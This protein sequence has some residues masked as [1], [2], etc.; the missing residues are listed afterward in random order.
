M[1]SLQWAPS[2]FRRN[3][4]LL[5]HAI[6]TLPIRAR[7]QFFI[8]VHM[9]TNPHPS[10]FLRALCG[11]V[12]LSGSALT[13]NSAE[14]QA[15]A[16]ARPVMSPAE[17]KAAREAYMA[18]IREQEANTKVVLRAVG[19]PG[20]EPVAM[21]D[22]NDEPKLVM[23]NSELVGQVAEIDVA[24][25][26]VTIRTRDGS[27]RVFTLTDPRPVK[28][29]EFSPQQV[30]MMISEMNRGRPRNEGAPIELMRTWSELSREAKEDILLSYLR[31]GVVIDISS[32]SSAS[33]A[34]LFERQMVQR[35][36]E[37]MDAFL[38]S[39]TPEQRELF[40][41]SSKGL[42]RIGTPPMDKEALAAKNNRASS[43]LEQLLAS[44]TADQRKLY[45]AMRPGQ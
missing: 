13:S 12:L 26:Q 38:A 30:E 20:G 34:R 28:F 32:R 43:S 3:R 18:K 39:L 8:T 11:A 36:Q 37:R 45:D 4:L 17:R 9:K 5:D 10:A 21:F 31:S 6:P 44:L 1:A 14:V 29:P 22:V 40:R 2:R 42:V 23:E 25:A 41:G 27:L 16:P 15:P 24:K 19:A 33:S 35:I 7:H